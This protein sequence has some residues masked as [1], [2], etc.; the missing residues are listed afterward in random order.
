MGS[1]LGGDRLLNYCPNKYLHALHSRSF[2]QGRKKA[3]LC[4]RGSRESISVETCLHL[5]NCLFV[6]TCLSN[7]PVSPCQRGGERRPLWRPA[8]SVLS[9]HLSNNLFVS[10]CLSNLPVSL[11]VEGEK[12]IHLCGV[13]P[14]LV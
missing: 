7:L 11:L 3:F 1:T 10:T 13:L 6:S 8:C 4:R 9:L 2:I 14:T 12:S 5:F